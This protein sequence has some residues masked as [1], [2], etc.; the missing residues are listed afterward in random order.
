MKVT[1]LSQ[2]TPGTVSSAVL[3]VE[4]VYTKVASR[5]EFVRGD[6]GATRACVVWG[7]D[8]GTPCRGFL[9]GPKT[10]RFVQRIVAS[11]CFSRCPIGTLTICLSRNGFPEIRQKSPLLQ[12][13]PLFGNQVLRP[14]YVIV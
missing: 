9:P 6:D 13:T 4:C 8:T 10:I 1:A 7:P 11:P 3:R 12:S 5:R 2:R 14:T